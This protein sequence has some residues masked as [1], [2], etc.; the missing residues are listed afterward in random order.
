M[1]C[2]EVAYITEKTGGGIDSS[3]LVFFDESL[4]DNNALNKLPANKASVD[5]CVEEIYPPFL[6]ITLIVHHQHLHTGIRPTLHN[7]GV[8]HHYTT[9]N[10]SGS[11]S[12]ST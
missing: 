5:Q 4:L 6:W 9:I 7:A 10:I 3:T 12:R 11:G 2:V 8:E 1:L